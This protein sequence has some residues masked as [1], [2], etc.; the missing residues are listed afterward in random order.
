MMKTLLLFLVGA[1]LLSGTV[2][3]PVLAGQSNSQAPTV[4]AVKSKIARQGIGAKAK[5]TI[6]LKNGTKVKGYV[7]QAEENDFVI[8][9]RKTDAPTT[10]RYED[11]LKV[12][13]NRGHST[14]R[15]IAIGV[16]VGVGAV[17]AVIGILISTLDD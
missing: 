9:D 11:V 3:P 12:E 4:E 7:A 2:S 10:I 13:E 5:V 17:L 8:R 6:R 14:A 1:V 15:N 16:A